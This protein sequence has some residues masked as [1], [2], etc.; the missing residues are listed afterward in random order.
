MCS[1]W[2]NK[3]HQLEVLTESFDEKKGFD[4]MNKIDIVTIKLEKVGN[5]LTKNKEINSPKDA[6]PILKNYLAGADREHLVL[7]TLN[8]ANGINSIS[9]ISIGSLNECI[10]HPREIFKTA[11]LTN[12]AKILLAHNHTSGKVT[13]SNA[14]INITKRVNEASK[15][16]GIELID[17]IIIGDNNYTS[18]KEKGIL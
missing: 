5:A 12:A 13:P 8:P 18:L 16:M 7:I 1:L 11:I 6:F 15:I 4:N 2:L 9:T 10:A 14:D 17:H 3:K